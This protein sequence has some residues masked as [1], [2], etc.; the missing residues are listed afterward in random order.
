MV[1][2]AMN[3]TMSP[4]IASEKIQLLSRFREDIRLWFDGQH[5]SLNIDR[6][7]SQI[8]RNVRAVR[9]IVEETSCLKLIST[10]PPSIGKLT[11]RDYDPFNS[12]LET[13]YYGVS[14]IPVIIEMIDEAIDVLESPRYTARLLVNLENKSQIT[15]P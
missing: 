2:I 4:P 3:N 7:R 8:K 1:N 6:L 9:S 13:P 10:T 12:V 5:H 11:V 14:F 15:P